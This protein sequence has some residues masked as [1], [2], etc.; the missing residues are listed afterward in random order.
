MFYLMP[1]VRYRFE[2][3]Y[4]MFTACD[5]TLT[6]VSESDGNYTGNKRIHWARR[7]K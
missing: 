7:T 1:K 3:K 4:L 5:K 2:V 6:A